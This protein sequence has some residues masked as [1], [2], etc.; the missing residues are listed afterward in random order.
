MDS[1][2]LNTIQPKPTNK[3]ISHI[4]TAS[5]SGNKVSILDIDLS[6]SLLYSYARVLNSPRTMEAMASLGIKP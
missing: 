2:E 3:L 4:D 6:E 5:Q 1:T